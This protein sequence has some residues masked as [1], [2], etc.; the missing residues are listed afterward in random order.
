MNI[1]YISLGCPKNEIDLEYI[2]G[3]LDNSFHIVENFDDAD[4]VIINTCAF[5]DPA[6][7]ESIDHILS[8]LQKKKNNSDF[9]V[10]V[11]GCLP[12][13]YKEEL[14]KEIPQ[15][16]E[17][18]YSNDI[19]LTIQQVRRYLKSES[20]KSE[21]RVQITPQ[22]YAYLK[23]A[24]GCNNRCSYCAIP[25]IK[26][27]YK[28]RPYR[29][30][31]DEACYLADNGVKEL[32][33]V[34]QDTTFYGRDLGN[35]KSISDLLVSLNDIEG[36]EWIRLLYTHPAHWDD[37]LIETAA[38]LDK[39]VKYIDLPI[40]HISDTVLKRM[41]RKVNSTQIKTLIEKLRKNIPDLALRTSVITGFPGETEKEFQELLAFIKTIKFERLGAFAYSHEE[42]TRAYEFDDDVPRKEKLRRQQ[43][44]MELQ[45]QISYMNNKQLIGKTINVM[46]DENE[47]D[48]DYAVGR[49]Q[50]D[51]PEI[52]NT[53]MIQSEVKAG[54]I[55]QVKIISADHY[56]LYG[57]VESLNKNG[58]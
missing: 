42:N 4:V 15:V 35:K 46:I 28:S 48:Q 27:D 53:V 12:Q 31:L 49:T 22:H 50:W 40:Q 32:L 29:K 43:K 41:G 5:I 11:S 9:K 52:D 7:Q 33:L 1:S 55:Y 56:D 44:I 24:D 37:R 14:S 21:T 39:I 25:L 36:L 16:D 58:M 19:S 45:S 18:F 8:A 23:I 17:Y 54:E 3:S 34:A 47:E 10:L 20:K 30:I 2:L 6:K 51:S 38:G 26:G 13:R 57:R